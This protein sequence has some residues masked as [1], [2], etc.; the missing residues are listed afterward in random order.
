MAGSDSAATAQLSIAHLNINGLSNKIHDIYYILTSEHIHVL[1]LSET[2][3]DPR[4]ENTELY[5]RGYRL[6]RRDRDSQGGGVALYVQNQ[7]PSY[8]R[9]DL[10]LLEIEIIWVEIQL[11]GK[12]I[13]VGSCYRPPHV[14]DQYLEKIRKKII[15][16]QGNKNI[17]I[18]LLGDFN[19][20]LMPPAKFDKCLDISDLKLTQVM[21]EPTRVTPRGDL[22]PAETCIDHIYTNIPRDECNPTSI[23][24]GCSDHNIVG[25]TVNRNVPKA[26][27]E[28]ITQ[29]LWTRNKKD[30]IIEVIKDVQ[31]DCVYND[32]PEDA[33]S[34]FLSTF[35]DIADK[36]PPLK[37][38]KNETF[39]PWFQ[40]V[41]RLMTKRDKA[42]AQAHK[43]K[44][45]HSK[46]WDKFRK[47]KTET[48]RKNRNEK[49]KHFRQRLNWA[50]NDR[51]KVQKI[52]E[53]FLGRNVVCPVTTIKYR[54][55][56][57]TE[58]ADVATHLN[59]YYIKEMNAFRS[60]LPA[61]DGLSASCSLI[62][63][64]ITKNK[65][66]SF[67]FKQVHVNKVKDMLSSLS[68]DLTTGLDDLPPGL[69]DLDVSILKAAAEHICRPVCHI[70]NRSLGEGVFPSQ[71]KESMVLP[72]LKNHSENFSAENSRAVTILPVL[73]QV[74]EKVIVDQ[75]EKYFRDNQLF[76]QDQSPLEMV[77]NWD[78]EPD[79]SRLVGFQF[80][81]LSASWDLIDHNW[82][83]TKLKLYG[84]SDESRRLIKS[85]L[86][87][88]KQQIRCNNSFSEFGSVDSGLPRGSCLGHLLFRIYTNDLL[89][90]LK[91][92]TA[93]MCDHQ[94]LVYYSDQHNYQVNSVLGKELTLV[95]NWV[96]NNKMTLNVSSSVIISNREKLSNIR[97]FILDVKDLDEINQITFLAARLN[98]ASSWSWYYDNILNKIH[99]CLITKKMREDAAFQKVL[100]LVTEALVFSVLQTPS[101]I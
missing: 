34:S 88:R 76:T 66:C 9:D 45:K 27:E 29:R 8:K 61:G 32:N 35:C 42:K 30:N 70:L 83:L 79:T 57:I 93:V 31:W 46:H 63:D 71:W 15:E 85:Y 69:E 60:G 19:D 2:H 38:C 86:S 3:L 92:S 33:L 24:T 21:T 87:G 39:A 49:N 43:S 62:K 12:P 56:L 25:V 67:S 58:A 89:L 13:L 4:T 11:P 91:E 77:D 50:K 81:D 16:K 84:F 80:L 22:P 82:L 75:I 98:Q 5:I 17:D 54:G 52:L 7:I 68:E 26:Q 101:A 59:D 37:T 14:K 6:Y 96:R 65:Q 18:V 48:S 47:L 64:K 74:L 72:V 100:P 36:N 78:R 10:S 99:K 53:D 95:W 97:Q 40:D 51:K 44:S 23:P 41:K 55:C 28:T 90:A 73:S 94:M 20:D 1:A